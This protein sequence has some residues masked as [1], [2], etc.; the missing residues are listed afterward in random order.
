M[1]NNRVL[2]FSKYCSKKRLINQLQNKEFF[3]NNT[4]TPVIKE[5][6][7]MHPVVEQLIERIEDKVIG[8]RQAVEIM[9]A[10]S[11]AGGHIL[12]EDLPG[13]AKTLLAKTF[14][15]ALALEFRRIQ[16]TPDLLPQ[17]ITGGY[18]FDRKEGA[19]NLHKGPVF[20]Q[21]LLADEINRAS[22][23]TQ[24]AMLEVMAEKQVTIEGETFKVPKHFMVIATQNP[25][26]FEST[27]PLPDAQM[28][29]FLVRLSLGYPTPE[30]ECL[31]L[32]KSWQ[33]D[34]E[35]ITKAL[36]ET[37]ISE[38]FGLLNHVSVS[39]E[40]EQYIV[41]LAVKTRQH[42]KIAVGVSP[43]GTKALLA[44]CRAYAAMNQRDYVLP[45]DVKY[46][47]INC[48][49]HRISLLPEFWLSEGLSDQIL[50]QILQSTQV[51]MFD[52]V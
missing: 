51:P 43:R 33:S 36:N 25:I 31:V 50:T 8:K 34:G 30:Q 24:S 29:R 5:I 9:I 32:R 35:E 47:L 15:D 14:S 44:L 6:K 16:F 45:D 7:E 4:A 37:Q 48:W 27:F 42:D 13:M 1:M 46:L 38:F 52:T 40:I 26:E 11:L 23:K 22:P 17:D 20:T 41:E 2:S 39:D 12:L 19:F 28:D 21:I 3:M 18:I 49:S 10:A